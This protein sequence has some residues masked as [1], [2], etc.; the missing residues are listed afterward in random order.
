MFAP[1]QLVD[2]TRY[3]LH[4]GIGGQRP[5]IKQLRGGEL[6][7]WKAHAENKRQEQ[8]AMAPLTANDDERAIA[9][10]TGGH[11]VGT[12]YKLDIDSIA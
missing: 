6:S 9:T 7:R 10:I 1:R 2:H 8:L 3:G 12:S 4:V 5:A 11:T